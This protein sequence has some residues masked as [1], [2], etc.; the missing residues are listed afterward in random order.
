VRAQALANLASYIQD[1]DLPAE[2]VGLGRGAAR[3]GFELTIGPNGRVTGCRITASGGIAALDA[4]TCRIMRAR[5]R[6]RPARDAAGNPVADV[7]TSA[8]GW[9]LP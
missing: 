6:F 1:G 9:Y 3:V 2:V 5:A 7:V 8:I 4:A